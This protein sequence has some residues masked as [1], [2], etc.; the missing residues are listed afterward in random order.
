MLME[1]I[2]FFE[3]QSQVLGKETQSQGGQGLTPDEEG[4]ERDARC[5]IPVTLSQSVAS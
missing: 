4:L 1:T 5:V 3:F 2:S